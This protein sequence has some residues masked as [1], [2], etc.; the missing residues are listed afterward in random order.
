MPK[1]TAPLSALSDDIETSQHNV[2][3][4]LKEN[5]ELK[6]QISDLQLSLDIC[7]TE[8]NLSEIRRDEIIKKIFSVKALEDILEL[9]R[10]L[11]QEDS[12]Y[13]G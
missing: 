12:A 6:K 4:I 9:K 7:E 5:Q 11:V 8:F 3:A 10:R 13:E 2:T 1:A